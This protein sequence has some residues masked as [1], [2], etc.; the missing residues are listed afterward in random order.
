ML[1]FST[2]LNLCQNLENSNLQNILKI[3]KLR[4][5]FKVCPNVV[6]PETCI[7]FAVVGFAIPAVPDEP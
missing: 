4:L 7:A 5:D 1:I 6:W 3:I 2:Y